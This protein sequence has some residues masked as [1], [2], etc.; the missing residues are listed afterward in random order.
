MGGGLP[1]AAIQVMGDGTAAAFASLAEK[2]ADL[3]LV[4]RAIH[5]KEAQ[6]CEAA[7][8]RRP[9]EYKVAVSGVAVYVNTNNTVKVLTY[10]ELFAIFQ[11]QSQ[12][13]KDLDGDKDQ[14]ISVYA[15]ATNS[16]N[17][18]LFNEEVLNGSGFPAEV[19]LLAGQDVLKAVAADPGHHARPGDLVQRRP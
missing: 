8:G 12:N 14:A 16:V 17:G 6:A 2:K 7:F 10:G 4:A 19:H 13:W 11:G 5:Y 9:A 1:A 15:Q 3:V 18:E